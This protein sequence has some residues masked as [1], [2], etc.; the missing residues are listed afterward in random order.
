MPYAPCSRVAPDA[1]GM[2]PERRLSDGDGVPCRHC[3]RNVGAGEAIWCWPTGR[4][5]RC[6]PMPRPGRSSCMP[7]HAHARD[8]ERRAAG[9]FRPTPTTSCAAT[10][11]TT[12]S[13]TAPAPWCRRRRSASAPTSCSHAAGHR[14]SAHALGEK[15][16]LRLPHR[17]QRSRSGGEHGPRLG[18]LVAQRIGDG[19]V[20]DPALV[21][22]KAVAQVRS[23]TNRLQAL[24]RPAAGRSAA[25]RC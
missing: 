25:W 21:D 1:Y 10:A 12:G 14:L 18:H 3:L 19:A 16:L 2:T 17:A 5:R 4:F 8:G 20:G 24:G 6:S 7:R 15:Q 11:R 13:S 9:M 23:S 22:V